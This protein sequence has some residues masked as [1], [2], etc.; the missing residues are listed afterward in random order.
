MVVVAII[1]IIASIAIPNF[2]KAKDKATWAV[3]IANLRAVHAALAFYNANTPDDTYP[4][5]TTLTYDDLRQMIPEAS[6][7][8]DAIK[9]GW[10]L[11][12]VSYVPS[13]DFHEYVVNVRIA[14]QGT[15]LVILTP[16]GLNPS[17]YPH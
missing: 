5:V 3:G 16:Q 14:T 4:R 12:L 2:L 13:V 17:V 10:D 9:G 1:A 8:D 11:S 6:L 15:Y 7:P